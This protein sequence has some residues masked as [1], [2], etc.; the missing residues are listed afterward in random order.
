MAELTVS[1]KYVVYCL[2]TMLEGSVHKAL[3]K[4]D[5]KSWIINSFETE[6]DA[7]QALIDDEKL[8]TNY[9]ILRQIYISR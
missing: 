1:K 7:I 5:F 8:F 6:E 2:N 9:V 4:I 3:E